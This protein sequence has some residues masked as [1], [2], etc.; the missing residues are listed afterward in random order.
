L[1]LKALIVGH[2]SSMRSDDV[3]DCHVPR[4]LQ[5]CYRDD[6]DVQVIGGTSAHAEIAEDISACEFVLFLDTATGARAG[7]IKQSKARPAC[8]AA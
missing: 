8:R 7:E 5:V 6:P 1:A 2:A 3:L 4:M